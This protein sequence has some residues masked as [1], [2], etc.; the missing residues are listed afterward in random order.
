MNMR[1]PDPAVHYIAFGDST[2][3]GPTERDYPD[4]LRELLD[5]PVGAFAN[6]GK[7]GESTEEGLMRLGMLLSERIYPNARVLLY[8]EGGKEIVDFIQDHDPL[9][10][11]AADDPSYPYTEELVGVL[12]KV[13]TNIEQAISSAADAGLTVYIATYFPLAPGPAECDALPLDIIL[14]LQA[15]NANSYLMM[16]NEH[17]RGAAAKQGA[18]IVDVEASADVLQE[19]PANYF[20]CNHLSAS[21]NEVVA[22]LFCDAIEKSSAKR[23]PGKLRD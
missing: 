15:G 23:S 12:A 21:G 16:L 9:L 20:D 18:T 3:A 6:E 22:H 8:W 2:T 14:P 1:V 19:N 11:F 5:E 4:I 13:Q 17:I 10:F 7:S